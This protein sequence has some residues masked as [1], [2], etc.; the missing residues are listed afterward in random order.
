M[1]AADRAERPVVVARLVGREPLVAGPVAF[2]AGPA[3]AFGAGGRRV[4]GQRALCRPVVRRR[5]L[6][7]LGSRGR[8]AVGE[9]VGERLLG[10]PPFPQPAG[11]RRDLGRLDGSGG[12]GGTGRTDGGTEADRATE[13]GGATEAVGGRAMWGGPVGRHGGAL[14]SFLLAYRVS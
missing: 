8:L 14:L 13:V 9:V 11:D 7:R 2:A 5:A 3:P 1:L 4:T 6:G 10:R 12:P